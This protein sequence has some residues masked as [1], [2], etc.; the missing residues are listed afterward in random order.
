MHRSGFRRT[1]LTLACLGVLLSPTLAS[2]QAA[3]QLPAP[4]INTDDGLAARFANGVAAVVEDRVITV[5][6][7]RRELAP[8][9]GQIRRESRN[10]QDFNDQLE[11]AQNEIVRRLVDRYLIVLEFRKDERRKIPASYVENSLDEQLQTQ[12]Q[13]DR[14]KLLTYLRARGLTMRDY[15]AE[16]EEDIIYGY[17]RQQQRKS[18]NVVSPAKVEA[19]Y[20]EHRDKFAQDEQIKMRMIQL[21]RAA[22]ESDDQLRARAEAVLAR[23]QAGESFEALAKDLTDDGRKARGGDWGWQRRADLSATF[24]EALFG[25]NVGQASAPIL[26]GESAFLL[27]AE[28][29]KEAGVPAI[30]EVREQIEQRLSQQMTREAEDKWLERLRR[31]AFIRLY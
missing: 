16:V 21:N 12:F 19:F 7:I 17:M 11:R 23:H 28:E 29:R 27:Y 14:A 13:G 15:R 26:Q 24:Q 30:T 5:D 4:E 8:I 20:T 1:F 25:L 6:D 9:V 2:A 18:Q 10:Q 31:D 3:A 22:A